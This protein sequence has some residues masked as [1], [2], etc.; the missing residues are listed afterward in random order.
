MTFTLTLPIGTGP[1]PAADQRATLPPTASRRY[2][3]RVVLYIEDNE[4]NVE[5]MRG[6]LA[7]R[8][9]VRLEV[10]TYGSEGLAAAAARPPHM[11]LLDMHLPDTTGLELL[12]RLK[13]NPASADIPVLAVSADALQPHIDAALTGGAVGYLTKPVSVSELLQVLDEHLSMVASN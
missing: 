1:N 7:Q 3:E 9:Q 2:D 10:A 5:V 8:P 13:S 4:T 11:I 6:I 12:R